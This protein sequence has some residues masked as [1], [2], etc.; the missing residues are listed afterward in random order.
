MF[1]ADLSQPE[2]LSHRERFTQLCG[3]S[4]FHRVDVCV[5]RVQSMRVCVYV[6]F[7]FEPFRLADAVASKREY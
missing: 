7:Q 6:V 2:V 3:I 5:C 4:A 1:F